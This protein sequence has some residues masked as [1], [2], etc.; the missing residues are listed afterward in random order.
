MWATSCLRSS[1][2]LKISGGTVSFRR[3]SFRR[4]SFLRASFLKASFLKASAR[5]ALAR[6]R[7]HHRM[8]RPRALPDFPRARGHRVERAQR[9]R[10]TDG[11]ELDLAKE[12]VVGQR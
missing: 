4:A 3:A 6:C 8:A 2:F 10:A 7:V 11:G 5:A 1:P 9:R 12:L